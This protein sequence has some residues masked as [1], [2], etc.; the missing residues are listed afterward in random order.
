VESNGITPAKDGEG[1]KKNKKNKKQK[2]EKKVNGATEAVVANNKNDDE[3]NLEWI[4]TTL[5]QAQAPL[6]VKQLIKRVKKVSK[7]K[8]TQSKEMFSTQVAQA[9]INGQLSP[10]VFLSWKETTH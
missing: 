4:K 3:N 1:S 10:H 7:T 2:S 5:Q 8:V 6:S 9:L